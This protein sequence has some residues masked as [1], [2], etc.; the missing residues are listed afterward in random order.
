[1]MEHPADFLAELLAFYA[2]I[3]LPRTLG[4]LGF[5][6]ADEAKRRSDPR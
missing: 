1:M 5:A 4:A 3:G 2:A 6:D